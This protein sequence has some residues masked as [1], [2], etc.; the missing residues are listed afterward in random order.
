MAGPPPSGGAAQSAGGAAGPPPGR[1]AAQSAGGVAG[2]PPSGGAVQ[3]AGSSVGP[4][5]GGDAAQPAGGTAGPSPGGSAAA[6]PS[7]QGAAGPSGR[8]AAGLAASEAADV[9]YCF[10]CP[11]CKDK[12]CVLIGDA[13]AC[14]IQAR[15][16]SGT[17]ITTI[18]ETL[19]TVPRGEQQSRPQ[20]CF[21]TS[22]GSSAAAA[23]ERK[24]CMLLLAKLS[25]HLAPRASSSA[26]SRRGSSSRAAGSADSEWTASDA[27]RL[28]QLAAPYGGARFAREV[29]NLC[30][31][32]VLGRE[33]KKALARLVASLATESPVLSYLPARPAAALQECLAAGMDAELSSA[34]W[35]ALESDAPVVAGAL[36][37]LGGGAG[38]P[39]PAAMRG[40]LQTLCGR[41]ALCCQGPGVPPLAGRRRAPSCLSDECLQTGICCGLPEVR[42]RPAYAADSTA[43]G[44]GGGSKSDCNHAFHGGGGKTG[45]VFTWFCEHGVCYGFYMIQAAE[46]RN[47]A[48]SFLTKFFVEA[49]RIVVY[50]FACALQEYCLNRAPEFFKGTLFVVDKFHWGGHSSCARSYSPFLYSRLRSVN[51]SIAE[52]CNAALKMIR[53]STSRMA[54]VSFMLVVRF[55]LDAWNRKKIARFMQ[56]VEAGAVAA[57]S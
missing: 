25:A 46:G 22:L 29:S 45:G 14:T 52:Q 23:G 4:P 33:G 49:P 53:S 32:G 5:P 17:P 6:Q 34:A 38:Q 31:S 2:A 39:L 11:I 36:E 37:T 26:G 12:P 48:F 24:E 8:E 10:F 9:P 7:G 3:S 30:S 47:E 19:A 18:D 43:T 27:A 1:G 44:T 55:F 40:L 15:Y 28:E 50:D 54:Q 57:S 35:A 42:G 21:C 51:T 56:L 20:R 16:Y 13:T 41:S